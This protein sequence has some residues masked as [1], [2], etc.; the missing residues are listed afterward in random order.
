M[1]S[2]QH[3]QELKVEIGAT[4]CSVLSALG[5]RRPERE[6]KKPNIYHMR[7]DSTVMCFRGYRKNLESDFLRIE[8]PVT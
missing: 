5:Y 6:A 8:H 1:C 2:E 7:P 4:C 3:K